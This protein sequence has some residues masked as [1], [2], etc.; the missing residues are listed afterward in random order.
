MLNHHTLSEKHLSFVQQ[1]K[2]SF[3][4]ICVT[5]SELLAVI[6]DCA[7][8]CCS[9]RWFSL[10]SPPSV[11]YLMIWKLHSDSW[12]EILFKRTL[13][14]IIWFQCKQLLPYSSVQ[15]YLKGSFKK[16]LDF[17]WFP[18]LL[19]LQRTQGTVRSSSLN[20]LPFLPYL[21]PSP[22]EKCLNYYLHF[23]LKWITTEQAMEGKDYC[24]EPPCKPTQA[25]SYHPDVQFLTSQR[26][27]GT[28]RSLPYCPPIKLKKH[29]YTS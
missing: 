29:L 2:L 19:L 24:R 9:H 22:W 13:Q 15:I 12:G 1:I 4:V 27:K 18:L 21:P 16:H 11:N 3:P 6:S 14:W 17:S 26:A 23:A 5:I 25:C 20:P 8:Y 28:G 7:F 10:L